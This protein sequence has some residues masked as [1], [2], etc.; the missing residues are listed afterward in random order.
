MTS[1]VPPLSRTTALAISFA[2]MVLL[3]AL[4]RQTGEAIG[5]LLD[6]TLDGAS[7]RALMAQFTPWQ[8][9]VHAHATL[10][11]DG[12]YPLAYGAFFTGLALRLAGP[13][14]RWV[15]MVMLAGMMADYAE[16]IVQLL[17]LSGRA[18]WLGTKIVLT[19]LK[20]ALTGT[21][22]VTTLAISARTGLR[23]LR[24]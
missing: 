9:D 2:A 7:A 1:P 15:A 8:R 5:G 21:A 22:V 6:L 10:I 16:N 19:P 18:D 23:A 4:L 24:T 12:L 11:Y 17:A 13:S 14:A 3:G 20:F